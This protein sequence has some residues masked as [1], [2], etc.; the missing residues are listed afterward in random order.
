MGAGTAQPDGAAEIT[1]PVYS[2]K[3]V[4][5]RT[6]LS[7]EARIACQHLDQRVHRA[8]VFSDDVVDDIAWDMMLDAL[9][10]LEEGRRNTLSSLCFATQAPLATASRHLNTLIRSGVMTRSPDP[11]D[12]R[13]A[14]VTLSHDAELKLRQL[15][16]Q[17]AGRE[18]D[19]TAPTAD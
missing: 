16:R 4:D 8:K 2:R 10:S 7:A 15:L 9:V 14:F 12:G 3:R 13:R 11:H 5:R 18:D 1:I 19:A 17:W 6:L